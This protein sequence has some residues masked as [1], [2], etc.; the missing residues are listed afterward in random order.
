MLSRAKKTS[1]AISR[2]RAAFRSDGGGFL[3]SS[4]PLSLTSLFEDAIRRSLPPPRSARQADLVAFDQ[5]YTIIRLRKMDFISTVAH[6]L[7]EGYPSGVRADIPCRR[8]GR[9]SIIHGG[10]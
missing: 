7:S 3:G 1:S 4:M 9:R 6:P 5:N 10:H 8:A 2:S